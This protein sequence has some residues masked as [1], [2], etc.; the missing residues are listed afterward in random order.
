M[1]LV[2]VVENTEQT[3]FRPQMDGQTD[4]VKPV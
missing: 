4:K 3:Q 1:D 2:S